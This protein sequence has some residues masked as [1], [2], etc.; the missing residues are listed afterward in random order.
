MLLSLISDPK[1]DTYEKSVAIRILYR[2]GMV[3]GRAEYL[4]L[5]AKSQ[6]Q[7]KI[8][9]SD[10]IRDLFKESEEANDSLLSKVGESGAGDQGTIID[11]SRV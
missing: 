3:F 11:E 10:E 5:A 1:S 7:H 2:L 8:D 6:K 9:I 4:I